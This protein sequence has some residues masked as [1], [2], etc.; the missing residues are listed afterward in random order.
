MNDTK[1]IELDGLGFS[2]LLGQ[3]GFA[4]WKTL[5][6]ELLEF[7]GRRA[8]ACAKWP[9][10]F[11]R[12]RSPQDVWHEQMR[13]MKEIVSDCETSGERLFVALAPPRSNGDVISRKPSAGE[14]S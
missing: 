14:L 8:Q 9:S 12:C 5:Q 10:D 4:A 1:P 11:S 2:P 3:E 7:A 6:Q 13:F